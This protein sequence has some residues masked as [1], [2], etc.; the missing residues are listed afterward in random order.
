MTEVFDT[1]AF[2]FSKMSRVMLVQEG[3]QSSVLQNFALHPKLQRAFVN[4]LDMTHLYGNM[5]TDGWL[6]VIDCAL[7]LYVPSGVQLN[8][9][10][11]PK[12]SELDLILQKSPSIRG[13]RDHALYAATSN[14]IL[15]SYSIWTKIFPEIPYVQQ[16]ESITITPEIKVQASVENARRI[17]NICSLESVFLDAQTIQDSALIHIVNS[18]ITVIQRRS[19]LSGGALLSNMWI[20]DEDIASVSVRLLVSIVSANGHRLELMW[21]R[22]F[23]QFSGMLKDA[24]QLTNA[25]QEAAIGEIDLLIA[26]C[27]F[28]LMSVQVLSHLCPSL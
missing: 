26:I 6:I 4:L 23:E 16:Q 1:L 17:L 15:K 8:L 18:L 27:M 14:T 25:L 24:R 28:L 9:P 2:N 13:K 5:L 12:E 11:D 3:L 19:L 10:L 21:P 7:S 20:L 22:V